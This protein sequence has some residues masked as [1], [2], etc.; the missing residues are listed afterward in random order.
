MKNIS[1]S[2]KVNIEALKNL[3]NMTNNDINEVKASDL[4]PSEKMDLIIKLSVR[5]ADQVYN[6]AQNYPFINWVNVAIGEQSRFEECRKTTAR[7]KAEAHF[8]LN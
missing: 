4:P 5:R 8:G 2:D 1:F 7:L 6:A 3:I